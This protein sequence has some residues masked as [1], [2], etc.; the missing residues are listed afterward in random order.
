L[1]TTLEPMSNPSRDGRVNV[2]GVGIHATSMD[3]AV[4]AIQ[5]AVDR[6]VKGYITFTGVHGIMEAQAD[7][8]LKRILNGSL[9]SPS[10]G[11]PA[12]W[13]GWLQGFFKMRQVPGPDLMLRICALSPENGYTHFFYGGNTGVADQLKQSFTQR[14][15]GLKVV[16]TY[17]P[18]FRPLNEREEADFI[19][20]VAETKPDFCWIGLS[21]PKQ[22]RFMH[23]YVGKLDARLLIGVGA[24]FDFHTGR[25]KDSPGWVKALGGGWINRIFQDPKRLWRRYLINNP[26]FIYAITLQLLGI[27]KYELSENNPVV[28]GPDALHPRNG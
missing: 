1:R 22:E 18:P 3:R 24:A 20:R 5:S 19:H 4:A 10:D 23:H 9:I 27:V 6:N 15:P 7:P 12:V 16:G 11:R 28:P 25:I 14:F 21:T 26:K 13:V 2:L 17:C 8:E